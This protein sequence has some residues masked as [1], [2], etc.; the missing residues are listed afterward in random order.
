MSSTDDLPA[1][2][3]K[4]MLDLSTAHMTAEDNQRCSER[5]DEIL[6]GYPRIVEHAYGYIV[7]VSTEDVAANL[8]EEGFSEAFVDI[9]SRAA[10]SDPAIMLINFDSDADVIE[11]LE[12]FDW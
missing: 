8:R 11:G 12:T 9:Y 5:A 7:F 6:G 10:A 1:T 3:I 4:L 2:A